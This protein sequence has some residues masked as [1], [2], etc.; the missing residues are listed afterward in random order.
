LQ[1]G[2]YV[3]IFY[4]DETGTTATHIQNFI[5]TKYNASVSAGNAYTYLIVIGDTGQ[6]P[7]YMTKTIDSSIGQCA[8]DLGYAAVNFTTSSTTNYFP[9]MY[10]SRI[11]VENTTQLTNY[12]NKVLTYEKFEFTDGGNYLNNVILVGGWDSNWTPKVAKPTINYG[13]TNYFK[14]SNTT[15]GGF[16]SGTI[17]AVVSTSSS[18]GYSGTNNG[19]YNGINNGSCFVNYTAHGDKQEWQVPQFTAAQVATLTNTGKY[20]FGV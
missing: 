11:S 1:K 12:L 18:Q 10:Y 13:T 15:Y 2:Y 4:T 9:D 14:T 16:G 5:K 17:N 6:V 19:V 3:D 7:Q 8:S 20:F